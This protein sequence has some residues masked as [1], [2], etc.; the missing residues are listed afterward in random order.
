MKTAWTVGLKAQDKAD[1]KSA[2]ESSGR[3]RERLKE[4]IEKKIESKRTEVRTNNYEN[5]NWNLLQADSIGYERALYEIISLI[6]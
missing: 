3:M 1:I 5:P 6:S 2:F 4:L